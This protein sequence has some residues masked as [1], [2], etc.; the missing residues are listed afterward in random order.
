[1]L[2]YDKNAF[3]VDG[4]EPRF[5]WTGHICKYTIKIHRWHGK[6]R[7]LRNSK[8]FTLFFPISVRLRSHAASVKP[9]LSFDR[10]A[11]RKKSFARIR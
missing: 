3:I 5:L 2:D 1:L 10:E 8:I 4:E 11:N 7:K 9:N 6:R